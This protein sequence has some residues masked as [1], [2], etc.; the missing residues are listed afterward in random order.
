MRVWPRIPPPRTD[1]ERAHRL[2]QQTIALASA[3]D[4]HP[5]WVTVL[6]IVDEHEQNMKDRMLEENLTNEQRQYGAGLAAGAQ[7]LANALRDAKL[8]AAQVAS[9]QKK[10]A[11]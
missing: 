7:Y 3:P 8:R 4:T 5:L 1:Q 6:Q 2:Q 11:E 10:E 9:R